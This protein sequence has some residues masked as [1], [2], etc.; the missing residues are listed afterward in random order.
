MLL[1]LLGVGAAG[2]TALLAR[3][4]AG[5]M[6]PPERRARGIALVLSGAVF[7]AILGPA[8][9]SPLVAD[10]ELD[11]GALA[12]LWLAAGGFMVIARRARPVRA[13]RP[14]PDRPASWPRMTGRTLRPR[15]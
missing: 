9:F 5:D 8:V 2:G 7:G 3:T 11:G 14:A 10:R 6:Y 12:V 13:A 4:A 15:R 1:G